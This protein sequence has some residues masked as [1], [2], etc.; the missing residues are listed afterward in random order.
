MTLTTSG[1]TWDEASSPAPV[2][3][4]RRFEDAWR[5]ADGSGRRPEPGDFL[6]DE[7][8]CPGARL[9]LLRA[10]MTLRWEAGEKVGASWYRAHYPGISDESLV[11]LIY[12]EFCLRE[13]EE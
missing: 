5:N 6:A 8:G 4:A 13:E 9:A 1:R 10:E 7:A 12:E 11:A 3:L 2:R